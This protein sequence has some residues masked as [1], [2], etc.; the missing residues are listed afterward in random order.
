MTFGAFALYYFYC[1]LI[2]LGIYLFF[3]VVGAL[4]K[5]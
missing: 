5:H 1:W 2:S 4:L 3:K